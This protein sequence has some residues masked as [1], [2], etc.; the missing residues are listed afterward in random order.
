MVGD[1]KER[2]SGESVPPKAERT[3]HC[4]AILLVEAHRE[5]AL[6]RISRSRRCL[7]TSEG[8]PPSE[9]APEGVLP[10]EEVRQ[11]AEERRM[12]NE[13]IEELDRLANEA[14]CCSD[15]LPSSSSSSPVACRPRRRWPMSEIFTASSAVEPVMAGMRLI[16]S[17]YIGWTVSSCAMMR[18]S[19]TT[20]VRRCSSASSTSRKCTEPLWSGTSSSMTSVSSCARLGCTSLNEEADR[21]KE[22]VSS[23]CSSCTPTSGG[24]HANSSSPRSFVRMNEV[25]WGSN[26]SHLRWK[27]A[28]SSNLTEM[29]SS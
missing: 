18:S 11:T 12:E 23:D 6:R 1:V 16:D 26:S 3:P 14:S 20:P 13:R 19:C 27:E 28:M 22:N 17:T 8:E 7:A 2:L 15:A 4:M 5:R 9:S 29:P 10:K 24:L 25:P 21:K